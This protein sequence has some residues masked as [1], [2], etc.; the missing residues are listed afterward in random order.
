MCL[1]HL[2]SA[3]FEI[4]QTHRLRGTKNG[5]VLGGSG[6][7]LAGLE[8]P[9][10]DCLWSFPSSQSSARWDL[11][12]AHWHP[13]REDWWKKKRKLFSTQRRA[14]EK[15][16]APTPTAKQMK[17]VWTMLK[18]AWHRSNLCTV[19]FCLYMS[20]LE[21]Y[22]ERNSHKSVCSWCQKPPSSAIHM[23]PEINIAPENWWLEYVGTRLS[24]LGKHLFRCYHASFREG[25]LGL[26]SLYLKLS[27]APLIKGKDIGED[28]AL[29]VIQGKNS[30]CPPQKKRAKKCTKCAL[31]TRKW[32]TT[33]LPRIKTFAIYFLQPYH[34]PHT[35]PANW[36]WA[37]SHIQPGYD[38]NKLR[39]WI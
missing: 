4:S 5:S 17:R 10:G 24:F 7:R 19:S 12:G 2:L 34:L 33:S 3:E 39:L 36:R 16:I 8:P 31:K 9:R 13:G 15:V 1:L 23:L 35:P 29:L 28:V 26:C 30:K 38:S 21:C 37:E 27:E 14:L 22:V 11:E 6:W 18:P 25:Y 20:L 32:G